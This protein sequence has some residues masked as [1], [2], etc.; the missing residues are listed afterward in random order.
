MNELSLPEQQNILY[1]HL[2]NS[3]D[4]GLLAIDSSGRITFCNRAAAALISWSETEVVG[5]PIQALLPV[6]VRWR[7]TLNVLADDQPSVRLWTLEGK[8]GAAATFQ[9]TVTLM[10]GDSGNP[11]GAVIRLTPAPSASTESEL[12]SATQANSDLI[13]ANG[14]LLRR[15]LETIPV[16]VWVV[17][18]Q[19]AFVLRNTADKRMW[20]DAAG[21]HLNAHDP[22]NAWLANSDQPLAPEDFALQRA[23]HSG[24]VTLN[25]VIEVEGRSGTRK[26][27]LNSAAPIIDEKGRL[28]GGI[29]VNQDITEQRRLEMAERKNRTFANALSNITAVLTSSLDLKTVMERILENVGRVVLHE[30]ANIMLIE[31][32][33][34]RVAFWHNYGPKCDELFRTSLYP[35]DLPMLKQMLATGLPTLV[36]DTHATP[37]W[38]TFPETDWVRSSV[39]VPI[40]S[41]DVILGFLTLDSGE[42]NFFQ[43]PDAERLRAFAYQSAIA[44]E[45]ARLFSTVREYA[46]ELE[47]RVT[48]RT[49]EL[50][51]AKDHVEAIL[52]HSS[53][54]IVLVNALGVISEVN[55][56]FRHLFG[57]NATSDDYP[58]LNALV[59]AEAWQRLNE[60]FKR[61]RASGQAERLEIVF[62]RLN[63][64]SFDVDMA[65]APLFDP[66]SESYLYVCDLHDITQQKIAERELR[67]ALETEKALGELKA[68]FVAMVSHEF[69]TP[70]ASIQT[71]TDL[72]YGYFDR[73]TPDRRNEIIGRI[74]SQIHRLTRLL[75]DVLTISKADTFGLVLDLSTVNLKT[76]CSDVITEVRYSL[77]PTREIVLQ[78]GAGS[79]QVELDSRLFQQL[80]INLLSNALKYSSEDARVELAL[81]AEA[82]SVSIRV[83]DYGIGIPPDDLPGLF[84]AF[85]RGGN[86]GGRQGTGLGL[87][88]VKRAVEAH[89]G[90]VKIDSALGVGTTITITLP[91]KQSGKK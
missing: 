36:S 42:P 9:A 44:I 85:Y 39:G 38:V 48:Q 27:L 79:W 4:Q 17:D 23:L 15:A 88:V 73:L 53:D 21:A 64:D 56:S 66:A 50:R 72:L 58:A 43:P 33:K 51:R 65:I 7:E 37:D 45:N 59:D 2:L 57:L 12:A 22:R 77:A 62:Q 18:Q 3:I 1:Q 47:A 81:T 28:I 83:R 80:L 29:E 70:L 89:H 8:D 35:L 41:R 78:E 54:A 71:S 55:P 52:E 25:E 6:D 82:E 74:Q 75:E 19:G 11:G 60:A 24:K 69:R 30:A 91:R 87:A 26:T 14:K 90:A 63:G 20:D 46:S 68:R 5:Q 32:D 13:E 49:A 34:V 10:P 67:S 31:D 86:V 76:L 40:R 61:V 84:E 16:G